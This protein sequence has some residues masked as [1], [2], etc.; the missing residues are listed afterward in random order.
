MAR[1]II[2]SLR[3]EVKESENNVIIW[4]FILKLSASKSESSGDN[5]TF[6]GFRPTKNRGGQN[7]SAGHRCG[8]NQKMLGSPSLRTSRRCTGTLT[9]V[10]VEDSPP[11]QKWLGQVPK[12]PP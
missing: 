10:V 4:K 3:Y 12:S 8:L 11:D 9:T 1:E 7:P 6:F 5:T 2:P